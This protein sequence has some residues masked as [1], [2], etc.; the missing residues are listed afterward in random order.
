MDAHAASLEHVHTRWYS[1]GR[2]FTL[3]PAIESPIVG[4]SLPVA[5]IWPDTMASTL[6]DDVN[7]GPKARIAESE[8]AAAPS[9]V[10]VRERSGAGT[11]VGGTGGV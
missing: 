7:S 5:A 11:T 4:L 10:L 2:S 9:W 1:V 8:R 6:G 3:T